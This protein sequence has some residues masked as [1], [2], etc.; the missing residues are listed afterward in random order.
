[1]NGIVF[2]RYTEIIIN[3]FLNN[4]AKDLRWQMV[5]FR[6]NYWFELDFLVIF[7]LAT[8]CTVYNLKNVNTDAEYVQSMQ[9]MWSTKWKNL[10]CIICVIKIAEHENINGRTDQSHEEHNLKVLLTR[11]PSVIP[12]FVILLIFMYD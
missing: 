3:E 9:L 8:Q 5:L 10:I 11:E 7:L 12:A 1:M 6:K 4:L 2:R